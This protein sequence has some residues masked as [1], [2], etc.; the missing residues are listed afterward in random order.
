MWFKP[1]APHTVVRS[2]VSLSIAL[3]LV[4]VSAPLLSAQ[5]SYNDARSN[6]QKESFS[7]GHLRTLNLAILTY[8]AD[9]DGVYPAFDSAPKF[10]EQLKKYRVSAANLICSVSNKPYIMNGKLAGKKRESVKQPHKT[11]LLWSPGTMQGGGYLILDAAGQIKRVSA[12]EFAGLRR[13]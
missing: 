4:W 12:R 3:G 6:L 10:R 5:K 8:T 7:R 13:N 9:N 11:L 2:L 1:F